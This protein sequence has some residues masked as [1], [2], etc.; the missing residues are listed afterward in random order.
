MIVATK[1][2]RGMIFTRIRVGE[3]VKTLANGVKKAMCLL[4]LSYPTTSIKNCCWWLRQL[5]FLGVG[6]QDWQSLPTC[7]LHQQ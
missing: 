4:S 7:T 3:I 5:L 2:K 6:W 1:L